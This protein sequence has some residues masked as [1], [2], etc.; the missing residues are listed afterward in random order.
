[1]DKPVFLFYCI[2]IIFVLLTSCYNT[3]K[4]ENKRD[5]LMLDVEQGQKNFILKNL[6]DFKSNIRYVKLETSNN[7]LI[8]NTLYGVYVEDDKIFI[9]DNDPFLKVFDANTGK[10]LYNIGSRGQGPGE[11]PCL[12][13]ID[14]NIKE[15]TILLGCRKVLKYNFEGEYLGDA[16]L[17]NLPASDSTDILWDNVVMHDEF[18]FSVGA[19]TASEHQINALIIFDEK[20]NIVN[21]LKSYDDYIQ[22]PVVLTYSPQQQIGFYYRYIDCVY[23]IRGLCD[24]VYAFNPSKQGF[25]PHFYFNFGKYRQSREAEGPGMT[26]NPDEIRVEQ[27]SENEEFVFI[28]FWTRKASTEPFNDYF[29]RDGKNVEIVNYSIYAVFDKQ[30]RIFNFLLQPV[31]GI[32]GLENDIDNGMPFWPKYISSENEF[33]DYWQ[34]YDFIDKANKIPN[35]DDSFKKFLESVDEEDNPIIIIAY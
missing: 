17:P 18:M 31:K 27:L 3:T 19:Y 29:V 24:T 16:T 33:A 14:I 9:R 32:R 21:T 28:D 6:T 30:E 2:T 4:I 8:G 20:S 10:F 5:I 12:R 34:A 26:L 23:F 11:L 15:R 7:C 13:S 1:M 35:P 25:E 22:H